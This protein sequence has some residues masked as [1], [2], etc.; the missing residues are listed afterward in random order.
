[1]KIGARPE[2]A[3][4][5]GRATAAGLALL[6]ALAGASF[7]STAAGAAVTSFTMSPS[8]GSSGSVVHV[9]G[10]GCAPGLLASPTT[11]FVSVTAPTLGVALHLPV[12]S[13]GAWQG[14]FT[15]PSGVLGNLGTLAAPVDAVCTSSG[16]ASLLTIY[17]PQSFQVTSDAPPTTTAAPDTAPPTTAPAPVPAPNGGPTPTTVAPGGSGTTTGPGTPTTQPHRPGG[18]KGPDGPGSP[19]PGT[20]FVFVPGGTGPVG[21]AA[22]GATE[23][24][25]RGTRTVGAIA[26]GG[27]GA[28]P[29]AR[30]GALPADLGS[31]SLAAAP[32]AGSGS[33]SLGWLVWLLLAALAVALIGAP[34]WLW[35]RRRPGSAEDADTAGDAGAAL[36]DGGPNGVPA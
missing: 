4:R 14:S 30:G 12:T 23:G 11:D 26:G 2:P 36:L 33:S 16:I 34:T 19:T 13:S 5:A 1:M 18:T 32:I 24:G 31:A 15:V 21:S 17:T 3:R 8:S 6:A 35:R 22:P 28:R 7:W 10:A 9:S 25:P 29:A 27:S 20:T